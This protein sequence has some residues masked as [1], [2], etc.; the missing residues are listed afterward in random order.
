MMRKFHNH[1]LQ[2]NPRHREEELQNTNS[3][4]TSGRQLKKNSKLSVFPV[5]LIA[6]LEGPKILNNNARTKHRTPT[7]N[8]S[9]NK[10]TY[11]PIEDTDQPAH[12]RYLIRLFDGRSIGSQVSNVSSSGAIRLCSDRAVAQTDFSLS[13]Y[14]MPTYCFARVCASVYEYKNRHQFSTTNCL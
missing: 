4:N 8:V 9:N 12:S 5:K 11:V 7:Y 10:L 1:T 2:T 14:H 13:C 6:K 3:H